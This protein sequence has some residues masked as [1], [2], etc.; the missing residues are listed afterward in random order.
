VRFVIDMTVAIAVAL[1]LGFSTAWFAV[2]YGRNWGT[3]SVGPWAA[4]PE[5]GSPDADPYAA[6]IVARSGEVPLGAAEGLA[7]T[8]DTDSSGVPLSGRCAYTIAGPTPAARLWTLTAYDGDGHLMQNAANRTG[9]NSRD[10][11]RGGDGSFA[12]VASASVEPG[13]W[14]PVAP[15]GGIDFILRLY[16]T[17]LTSGLPTA[18]IALPQIVRGACR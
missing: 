6:A 14:L 2:E 1:V 18:D 7:F 4:W 13:N 17:P 11:V 10:L 3:I 15:G 8:A 12:I 16:D 5:A 9:F